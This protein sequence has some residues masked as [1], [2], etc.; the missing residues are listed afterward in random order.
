MS[1]GQLLQVPTSAGIA[2]VQIP[3]GLTAGQRFRVRLPV[4]A[5][6]VAEGGLG[7]L[8]L[9]PCPAART[10]GAASG[11]AAAPMARRARKEQQR[12][13]PRSSIVDP[14]KRLKAEPDGPVAAR[15]LVGRGGCV[16]LRLAP[17]TQGMGP[18]SS[19]SAARRPR[20]RP[21]GRPQSSTSIA[22]TACN[23]FI[24]RVPP[25]HSAACPP[26]A[27]RVDVGAKGLLAAHCT[28]GACARGDEWADALGARHTLGG[29]TSLR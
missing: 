16:Q 4:A 1:G 27:V 20:G 3:A 26:A 22:P 2:R 9:V 5:Q 28:I 23:L 10:A 21:S 7:Q 15:L 18:S 25:T 8:P 17:R 11:A 19:A 29:R 24:T 6:P 12:K 14:A 13:R